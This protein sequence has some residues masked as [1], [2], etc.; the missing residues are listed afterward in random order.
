MDAHFEIYYS[1]DQ[2]GGYSI[3]RDILISSSEE[4]LQ[5]KEGLLLWCQRKTAPYED[6]SVENFTS[7][8]VDGLAL[9]ALIHCHRP[10]LLDYYT[11][12]PTERFA[13]TKLAFDIA[14][15]HLGIPVSR[16]VYLVDM[17]SQYS[18]SLM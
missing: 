10:D 13:N 2:V 16:Y 12:D 6:V 1:R 18:N 5:A 14:E 11:L 17:L 9:C 15:E 7:S 3:D 4:G 8:W